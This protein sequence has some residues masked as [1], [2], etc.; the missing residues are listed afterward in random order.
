[1]AHIKTAEQLRQLYKLPKGRPIDK[2][3]KEFEPHSRNFIAHSPFLIIGTARSDG[4]GDVS[5]RGE[6]PGFVKVIDD[7]TLA[8]PDRP[9]NNRLDTLNNILERPAV[10]LIFFIPGVNET[11]RINGAAEIRDDDDLREL[12]AVNGRLPATVLV[13]KVNEIY[14]HCAKAL[15]RSRLWDEDAKIKRCDFPTMG[16]MIRDQINADAEAEP[17]DAMIERYEQ[18][19][20]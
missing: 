13:V 1:M 12:F 10:G 18:M 7:T 2:V 8:I 4:L 11:L 20:Y 14:L 5:P 15:M 6:E 19:L 9:G 3:I 16:E 17:N